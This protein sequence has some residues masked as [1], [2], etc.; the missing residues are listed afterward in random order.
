[1]RSD[2]RGD[3]GAM[4]APANPAAAPDAGDDLARRYWPLTGLRLRAGDLE[5]RLPDEADLIALAA[6][7]EEGVHDP[8]VQPFSVAW[9]DVDPAERGRSVLQY[10]WSCLGSWRPDK[11]SL[12]LAVIRDG[13]VI[14][15]QGIGATD[16]VVLREV[17]TGSWLG[18]RFQGQGSGTIMRAA[19]LDF[20]FYGLQAEYAMSDAFTDNPASLAVSRKLGY[21]DDG[22]TRQVS[23]GKPAELR[24]LRMDRAMWQARQATGG[25]LTGPVQIEGLDPCLPLFGLG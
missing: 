5:L 7:A 19:V 16:F 13:T 24:R 10:Q 20:A 12:N 8:A 22:I 9:T 23:R 14:G 4:T 6:L 25:P 3:T 15:T 2:P 17:A 11:W 1:L 21:R 18:R